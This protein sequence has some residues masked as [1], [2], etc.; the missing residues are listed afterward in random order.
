MEI[1]LTETGELIR[2]VITV[3]FIGI[4]LQFQ[5]RRQTLARQKSDDET[6]QLLTN[7][8][9]KTKDDTAKDVESLRS[10][11]E[12]TEAQYKEDL[13]AI[14]KRH[15][16]ELAG[17]DQVIRNLEGDI[18][19]QLTASKTERDYY[20]ETI[21]NIRQDSRDA[22]QVALNAQNQYEKVQTEKAALLEDNKTLNTTIVG[23]RE[24]IFQLQARLDGITE[25]RNRLVKELEKAQQELQIAQQENANLRAE[26]EDLK[27]KIAER[28]A[29][30][31]QLE[32]EIKSLKVGNINPM[33]VLTAPDSA[34]RK[35]EGND[36]L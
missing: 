20:R 23:Q 4:G 12:E 18:K 15:R 33:M 27:R 19:S 11:L 6:R 34:I 8:L 2:L 5:S 26:I 7:S 32:K 30:I 3:I 1:S 29:Q 25:E 21:N 22:L 10:K 35:P 28:D 36:P 14:E 31:L 17:R 9:I 24:T 13:R 16:E